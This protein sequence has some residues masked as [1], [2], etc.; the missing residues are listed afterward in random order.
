MF[1]TMKLQSRILIGYSIPLLLSTLMVAV[2]YFNVRIAERQNEATD[3]FNEK[4]RLTSDML[5]NITKMQRGVRG[6]IIYPNQRSRETL[7]A[8]EQGAGESLNRLVKLIENPQQHALLLKITEMY[9]VNLELVHQFARHVDEGKPS[10]AAA[11]FKT[12]HSQDVVNDLGAIAEEFYAQE[13]ELH[14]EIAEADKLALARIASVILWGTLLVIVAAL[15]LGYYISTGISSAIAESTAGVSTSTA[16]IAATVNQHERTANQQAAMVSETSA[17][18]EELGVS[19]RKTAEQADSAA[20]VAQKASAM[21]V[22]G[23]NAVKQ[24]VDGMGGL[25]GRIEEV[26]G[27]VLRLSEQ[28]AQIGAIATVVGDLASQTNMLALNAAVEAARAGEYGK[29]FAVVATEVRKLADQSKKSAAEANLL[30][31]EIQKATNSTVM[32]IEES[33]KKVDDITTLA[34]NVGELFGSISTAAG[35]VYGSAQQA[36]LNARQQSAA[37]T[38]VVTAIASINQGA[39]E[40]AEGLTQTKI[41]I[42]K[43]N[44]SAQSLKAIT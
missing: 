32:V 37:L 5:Y 14:K 1:K 31:G 24:A 21:T 28:T 33:A 26:A 41:G 4:I 43:L 3:L 39:K 27:Q 20:T 34:S 38:Q 13:Y 36:L 30:I 15:A 42:Q 18:V 10:A 6:Y 12:G 44:E 16:E 40:T 9:K 11:L 35:D 29:G 7:A 17:T 23:M 22:E 8:A 25:K 2:V 19:A